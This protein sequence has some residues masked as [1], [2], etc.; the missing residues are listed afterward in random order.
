MHPSA[1][2]F[3]IYR[4]T[5][6]FFILAT[7]KGPVLRSSFH[8]VSLPQLQ[9]CDTQLEA[10]AQAEVQPKSLRSSPRRLHRPRHPR[11]PR[12]HRHRCLPWR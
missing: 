5:E 1:M 9:V 8:E 7:T 10:R 3:Q 4:N 2:F 11:H 6:Y 12:N